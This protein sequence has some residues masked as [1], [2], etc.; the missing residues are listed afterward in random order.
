MPVPTKEKLQNIIREYYT[1][2]N[3]PTCFGAID[4]KHC[5][6]KCPENSAS[7]Y[8]CCEKYFCIVLQGV[9]D[10]D[11]KFIIFEVGGARRQSDGGTFAASTLYQ[12]LEDNK[13]NVPDA[14]YLPNSLIKVP[15]V[16][17]GDEAHPLKTYLMRPYPQTN[18]T[19]DKL[20]FNY[21]LSRTR[22]CVECTFGIFCAKWRILAKNVETDPVKACILIKAACMS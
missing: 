7:S 1:R 8:Y 6:I 2:W 19:P 13:F 5:R 17:I 12:R 3:F 15:N 10:A 22:K 21:R 20:G 4:G 11:Y 9:S 18:L 16:L 14:Q